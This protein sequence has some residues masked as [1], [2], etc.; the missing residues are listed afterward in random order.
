MKR[1]KLCGKNLN[2]SLDA[3]LQELCSRKCWVIS[4]VSISDSAIVAPGSITLHFP[5][6]EGYRMV[7]CDELDITRFIEM[8]FIFI[9]NMV[10]FAYIISNRK[11]RGKISNKFF[12]NV[13]LVHMILSI[14]GIVCIFLPR[15]PPKQEVVLNNG[16]LMEMFFSLIITTCDRYIAIEYPYMYETLTTKTTVYII[17][18]SWVIPICFVGFALHF[19]IT[20]H[21]CTVVSTIV[22]AIATIILTL[23]NMNVYSIAKRSAKRFGKTLKNKKNTKLLKSTYVCFI[24]V[25]SFI[26]LWFPYFIHNLLAMIDETKANNNNIFTRIVVQVA[27]LNSILHPVLFVLFRRDI[28]KELR[29]SFNIKKQPESISFQVSKQGTTDIKILNV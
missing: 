27:L 13:Q 8:I 16:F 5:E 11:L 2:G 20:Q 15:K 22:I 29:K 19:D 3:K 12:L 24:L 23:S 25:S 6:Y 17:M 18:S 21:H 7:L 10:L 26:I 9:F 4:D 28:K 1:F 14:S